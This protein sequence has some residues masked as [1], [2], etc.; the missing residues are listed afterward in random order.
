[1]ATSAV[2]L[3]GVLAYSVSQRRREIGV[4]MALGA[5]SSNILKLIVQQ[6]LA[7][8]S[9]GL[10]IGMLAALILVRFMESV[11]YWVSGHDP[12]SLAFAIVVLGL[13]GLFACFLPAL[14]AGTTIVQVT[15]SET[16]ASYGKRIIRLKDGW[17]ER[18]PRA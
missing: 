1:M 18:S 10:V 4:R 6:G 13:A 2:G 17:L 15:H 16:N 11:L 14:R 12:L 7:L 8:L 5:Q 3:Y 9:I